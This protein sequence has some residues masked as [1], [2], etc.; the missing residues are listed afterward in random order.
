[1]PLALGSNLSRADL[2]T[3]M[4]LIDDNIEWVQPGE[5]AISGG[6]PWK[7]DQISAARV[8]GS[9]R[10]R[11][12][13]RSSYLPCHFCSAPAAQTIGPGHQGSGWR[14]QCLGLTPSFCTKNTD[15]ETWTVMM[16][17]GTG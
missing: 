16:S 4:N 2:E 17:V 8:A 5:S 12:A 11:R 14:A 6:R 15:V 7:H 1:V 13:I 3:I 9:P 10:S